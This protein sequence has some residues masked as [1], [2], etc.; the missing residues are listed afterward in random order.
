[1]SATET[2]RSKKLK[3]LTAEAAIFGSIML[4]FV[5]VTPIYYFVAH[6]IVGTTALTLAGVLNLII[7]VY[8][9]IIRREVGV[10]RPEDDPDGEIAHGAGVLG[11]FP[12][13]SIWPMWCAISITIIFLGPVFGWWISMIGI[14]VGIWATSGLVFEFYRGDY[15]H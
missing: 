7:F 1:M 6:E 15:A 11:F 9:T 3:P 12:P 8:L 13:K 10:A 2:A 14:G 5:I 4:F